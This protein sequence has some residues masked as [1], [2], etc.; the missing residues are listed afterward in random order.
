MYL[1]KFNKKYPIFDLDICNFMWSKL[2]T[3]EFCKNSTESATV[4]MKG[5]LS[6]HRFSLKHLQAHI[7]TSVCVL[8]DSYLPQL[9]NII[10]NT[11]WNTPSTI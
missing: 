1:L 5:L 8:L 10:I 3:I 4:L 7:Y 6:S 11:L 2:R 9:C